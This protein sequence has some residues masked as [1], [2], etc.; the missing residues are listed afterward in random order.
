MIM[1]IEFIED[2]NNYPIIKKKDMTLP[3]KVENV[4][5]FFNLSD[6]EKNKI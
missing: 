4:Q 1:R 2:L 3:Y 6:V 5:D